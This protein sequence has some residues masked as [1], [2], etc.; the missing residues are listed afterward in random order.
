MTGTRAR[1]DRRWTPRGQVADAVRGTA[2]RISWGLGDQAVSSLTNFAVGAFVAR[3]LG[4]TAFGIFSLVWV[5]YGVIVNISRG[6][7]S[8]PLLVRF[9]GE[10]DSA[11]RAAVGRMTGTAA[12]IGLVVGIA[13]VLIGAIAG[14]PL[15]AAFVALGIV[16]P[17]L[18][19]QDA[20]RFAFFAA[21][22]GR[23]AFANDLLWGAAL[24][25]SMLFTARFE[26][27]VSAYVLAWGLPAA[28]AAA[29]GCLQ[30]RLLPRPA[31][32]RSWL[33]DHRDLGPRYLA[34]NVCTGGGSQLRMYGVGAV[35]GLAAV[36]T[37]RGGELLVGPFLA[38]LMGLSLVAVPEAARVLRRSARRLPLFCAVLGG[39]QAAAALLWGLMLL[40][41]VPDAAGRFVLGSLW[42]PSFALIVP[43]TMSVMNASLAMGAAAGLRALGAARRSLRAQLVN[44]TAYVIG[45]IAGA[46]VAGAYGSAWGVAVATLLGAGATWL[47]FRAGLADAGHR[48]RADA[49]AGAPGPPSEHD[50]N[51]R[52][53]T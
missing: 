3:T 20:W 6:L 12:V 39:G 25:P 4:A 26:A 19:L 11:Q 36:G 32:V 17:A 50:E 53:A 47:Q 41:V 5:T 45:G 22:Q 9:S 2:G 49:A 37:I 10:P 24:I 46:T 31:S 27:G 38:V 7:A 35:A 43:I 33:R 21:G 18:L 13:C 28:L 34:E 40:F 16:A 42:E 48:P 52:G 23:K 15:G 51:T 29:V 8:D 44:S 1:T 30:A 14:G